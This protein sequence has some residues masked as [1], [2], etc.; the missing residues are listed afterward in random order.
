MIF[1]VF[2]VNRDGASHRYNALKLKT[3]RAHAGAMNLCSVSHRCSLGRRKALISG[4]WNSYLLH[5]LASAYS[6][7]GEALCASKLYRELEG[8]DT[9]PI[10]FK[11]TGFA[12]L[13]HW[14]S[15][16]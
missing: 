12:Q 5:S 7:Y 8:R 15:L 11:L 4:L 6:G 16:P 10:A 9:I 1:D 2:D 13:C 14:R 3:K